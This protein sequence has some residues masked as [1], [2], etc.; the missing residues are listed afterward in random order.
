MEGLEWLTTLRTILEL[1][2]PAI[3]MIA[4]LLL[5]RHHVGEQRAWR[6]EYVKLQ[7]EYVQALRE[8]AGLRTNLAPV[9]PPTLPEEQKPGLG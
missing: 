8:V 1:G 6:D 9:R 4:I 3:V 5:W 7:T 2:W